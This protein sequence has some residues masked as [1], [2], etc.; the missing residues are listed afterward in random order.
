MA[1]LSATKIVATYLGEAVEAYESQDSMLSQ[2][3]VINDVDPGTL[4]NGNNTIWRK[5]VQ[6][7]SSTPGFD[8]T[9]LEQGIISQG[10]YAY[11]GTP[12]NAFIGLRADDLRD[13]S[14]IKDQAKVD[15]QKR[16][17][18]LNKAITD[19]ISTTGSMIYRS[20]AT[21]G[22]DFVSLAQAGMNKRQGSTV[23][24]Y[25]ALTDTHNQIFG[26]DLAS[27]QTLQGQPDKTYQDGMLYKKIAGFDI[28]TN[29]SIS[30]L[31]GGA[32]PAT[33]VTA[34]VSL[35]PLGGTA[36]TPGLSV[37]QLAVTNNDY[38]YGEIAVTAS[39]SYNVGDRVT[40][41]NGGV[42]VKAVGRDDKTV[43]DEAM[44]FVIVAKAD[45]THIT[46]WPRPIA[47]NDAGLTTAQKA[48]ANIN[49]QILNTATVNRVNIDASTQPS[50]FWQKDSIEVIGGKMPMELLGQWGGMKVATEKLKNGLTMYML[51][52]GNIANLQARWR[53][54]IWY[55]VN[56][57]RPADN[58]TLIKF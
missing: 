39:G 40:F 41:A 58:G 5:V 38:R 14:Y 47:A 21:S 28:M 4:Q 54:F 12:D 7:G 20:N 35:A 1:A 34:N 24:R 16:A 8:L 57:A 45:A 56:N 32:D 10:Y 23:D 46:V 25:L 44:T 6:Q 51:Y 48:Y 2:V 29:S 9:G 30:A 3:K 22:F 55:G 42:T 13:L 17:S 43:T 15:G 36:T 53:M 27:R 11:L 19:T 37:A 18:V 33:T 49:T 52:D 50:I 26:K 31:V